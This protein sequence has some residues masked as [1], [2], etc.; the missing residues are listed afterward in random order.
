MPAAPDP[1]SEALWGLVAVLAVVGAA[2]AWSGSGFVNGDAAAYLAQALDGDLGQRHIHVGYLLLAR[3]L[4]GR[5]SD[6]A[7]ALDRLGAVAGVLVVLGAAV[8]V[9]SGAGRPGVAA[10]GAA[11]VM[12]PLVAHAEVDPL[13]IAAVVWARALPGPAAG[14]VFALG[15]TVSPVALL[16]APWA[17]WGDAQRGRWIAVGAVVALFGLTAWSEGLWWVGDRGVL[18][19]PA[20][21]PLRVLQDWG[22]VLPWALLP[23]ALVSDQRDEGELLTWVP[24]LLAPPDVPGWAV[25]AM[26][27]VLRAARGAPLVPEVV[28]VV[29][30]GIQLAIGGFGAR[31]RAATVVGEDRIARE[32]GQQLT[33]QD[34][35]IAPFT[36]G[37][38][39]SV[40]A[41]GDPYGRVWRPP[42][43]FLRSQADSWCGRAFTR[44]AVLP[45]VDGS[46]RWL[47]PSDPAVDR[48]C[49][50]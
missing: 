27:L 1:R 41:T 7:L 29:L 22:T 24:M 14:L 30:V 21:R 44:V 28:P 18:T 9:R 17:A 48:G 16:A 39:V 32:L 5:V 35:L 42:E 36:W 46:V 26:S 20:P 3:E 45:P 13:W 15:V 4:V 49:A 50:D 6:P 10:L 38:R 25:P 47:D 11:A 2:L 8:G 19:A 37:A 33:A 40:L 31:E 43:G 23:L 34:G 12:V